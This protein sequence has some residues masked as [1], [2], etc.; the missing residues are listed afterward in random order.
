MRL[1]TPRLAILFSAFSFF[2][3]AVIASY[4]E[5][6]PP[7]NSHDDPECTVTSPFSESFFD[8]RPLRRLPDRD[9]PHHDWV[10][11]GQDYGAN[12]TINICGPVLSDIEIED[13]GE[14]G[15]NVSAFFEK[16]GEQFS[17]GS[18]ST[19][20][21]FRGRKLILAYDNGSP[22]PHAPKLRRSSLFSLMCDHEAYSKPSVAFVG[23]FNDCAYFFEI[24]TSTAC[25]KIKP[26]E[27]VAP[28]AV[29]GIIMAVAAVA[30]C[31]GGCFYQRTVMHARGWQQIPHFAAWSG[32][33]GFFWS[34]IQ[35]A[36]LFIVSSIPLP[37]SL[38]RHRRSSSTG[39]GARTVGGQRIFGGSFGGRHRSDSM[40]AE[41]RLIDE[42]DDEWDD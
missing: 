17:I 11:K 10:V 33:L 40:E 37:S 38:K 39:F 41:N 34:M 22:C 32:V 31:L 25:A 12:F 6:P 2:V 16:D 28:V 26:A 21:R 4:T 30:Y 15:Q 35:S 13:L 24:R 7:D 19:A 20:P 18:V 1:T 23:Q 36:Y 9:P 27:T 8:L 5:T 29:F 14:K 3:S 42:L